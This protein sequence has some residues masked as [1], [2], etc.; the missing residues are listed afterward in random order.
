M[1]LFSMIMV[2][3]TAVSVS[4][5]TT[6]TI[7]FQPSSNWTEASARFAMYFFEG[8]NE[9]WVSMTKGS[10]GYYEGEAPS[11]YS[12]VIFVRMNPSSSTNSWDN[13]WNQTA[14]LTIPDGKN[15][16]TLTSSDWDNGTGTW[17]YYG[18]DPTDAPTS[19]TSATETPTQVAATDTIYF[20]P[21]T[22]WTTANARFAAY[23]FNGSGDPVWVSLTLDSNGYYS[24]TMPSGDYESVIFVRM[25]PST[26]TNSWDNKW[27]QTAD[28]TIPE[29]KN[30]FTLDS[31]VWDDGTGTWSTVGV[32]P[33][34]APTQI[35]TSADEEYYLGSITSSNIDSLS[36][37]PSGKIG[38]YNEYGKK[39]YWNWADSDTTYYY[40]ADSQLYAVV[41]NSDMTLSVFEIDIDNSTATEVKKI[42]GLELSIF[43]G[44][45]Y[46]SDGNFYVAVGE[47][48]TEEDDSNVVIKILKYNS[49]WEQTGVC[50]I[51]G[52]AS[53][54]F[55]GIRIPFYAGACRMDLNNGVLIVHTSR[56]MYQSSDG[57][58]HQGDISF[59]IDTATMTASSDAMPYSSHS[60]N[61][62]VKYD[63][64]KIAFIDH[65][66]AYPRSVA[67]TVVDSGYASSYDLFAFQGTVG[68]NYTGATVTGF[69]I[70]STNYIAVGSSVPHGNAVQG[71]TGDSEDYN[72]NIYIAMATKSDLT[73]KFV[74]LTDNDPTDI[75][76]EVSEPRLVKL[77]DN[78]FVVM[79]AEYTYDSTGTSIT[80][81]NLVCKIIDGSGNITYEKI[82]EDISY[83][84]I[85]QPI[86]T[87]SKIV[88]TNTYSGNKSKLFTISIPT[89]I[90]SETQTEAP[91]AELEYS[92]GSIKSNTVDNMK[93][94]QSGKTGSYNAYYGSYWNW[95]ASDITYYYEADNQLYAVVVNDAILYVYSLDEI[96]RSVS[97]IKQI[98]LPYSILGSCCYGDD[99]YFYVAVGQSNTD[100]ND[101]LVVIQVLKYDAEWNKV[102]ECSINGNASNSGL[103]GINTP[104]RAGADMD[105]NNGVL[106]LHTSR[107]MYGG[108]QTNISFYINTETMEIAEGVSPYVAS[109][110]KQIVKFDND[111]AVFVDHGN[112]YPRAIALNIVDD[113]GNL[114]EIELLPLQG[115]AGENYTGT[116][117]TGLEI[118]N[119]NYLVVGSSVPHNNEV[120]GVTGYSNS[121][122]HNIYLSITSKKA[123][124]SKFV[125]LTENDPTDVTKEVSEPRLVKITDNR[126]VVMYTEYIY[127]SEGTSIIDKN[128]V[129]KMIDGDGNVVTTQVYED[130]NYNPI[131]QPVYFN[132]RIIWTNTY[133]TSE[134]T[135]FAVYISDGITEEPTDPP[136][137]APTSA[138]TEEE[139]QEATEA[140]TEEESQVPT[141]APTEEETQEFTEAPTSASTSA[142]ETPTATEK[143]DG[144][145][146]TGDVNIKLAACGTNKVSGKIALQPG[147]YK[148][149]LNNNGTLM[150]YGKTVTDSSKGMT[151]N[152]KYSSFMTLIASGGVYTF[153]VNV[154]TNTLVIKYDSNLPTHY[155]TGDLNTIL[156]PVEGRT[157]AIGTTYLEAGTYSFKLSIDAVAFG[158][159]KTITDSTTSSMSFNSKYSAS[160]TLIATGGNYT[161]TLNTST[162]KLLIKHSPV[163]DEA[164]DDVHLSGDVNIVLDDDGGNSDVATATT[165]LTEGTYSF[166]LYNYGQALTAGVKITDSGT[167]KLYG[168]YTTPL[169]LI[170]SGGT[171]TI[172]FNKTTNELTVEKA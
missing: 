80:S 135:L 6:S 88:W 32:V 69:E 138:P 19:A 115:S 10:S 98:E 40:E 86:Y 96:N 120:Q 5:E 56:E 123:L 125:W 159:G 164:V 76:K 149:K 71:I 130:I 49:D 152:A 2:S 142:T 23:F 26:T 122:N 30:H 53:N 91:T 62:F 144:Y 44:F 95:S 89:E 59:Y 171:Y 139:T 155:L 11:G 79:F 48:N 8:S 61:Q 73:T 93:N 24:A 137:E 41:V 158:Y 20:T 7:Y 60:F 31:G 145:Y 57:Y 43:G 94:Y 99:G 50:D 27:N 15:L 81:T 150:G 85:C 92:F 37:Y 148:L 3:G 133:N 78:S 14:D 77:S 9:K 160:A 63:G 39:F 13:K 1:M 166:K 66:D 163:K 161:F 55:K 51:Y 143:T 42:S 16:F 105:V 118:N 111:N 35:P 169:T 147:T 129:C 170:V 124:T 36:D 168:N 110:Y 153:Q 119:N 83:N 4:A 58:C 156:S 136:T 29:G 108:A 72:H 34:E 146:V 33:T 21:S 127:D 162:N 172:A 109:S 107:K 141:S 12:N 70:S 87:D 74:W 134:T 52:S 117:V 103:V 17:S 132:S 102:D 64:D 54:G 131:C 97:L 100:E 113:Y 104:F 165:T 121:Y 22:D 128:L 68:D 90:P 65:G 82:Y 25:D 38:S 101:E 106:V 45:Y 126:Y 112:A 75:T 116:T 28:L 67:L 47:N 167:K 157:L 151:F 154:D 84:P 140:P 114:N 18:V 46:G